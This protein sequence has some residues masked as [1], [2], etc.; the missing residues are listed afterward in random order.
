MRPARGLSTPSG[1][2]GMPKTARAISS[3]AGE[4]GEL[5]EHRVVALAEEGDP[6]RGES[7]GGVRGREADA[8]LS[9][10]DGQDAG[11]AKRVTRRG[12]L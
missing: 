7:P 5:L 9:E 10:I 4:A 8:P 2:R 12:G 11:H 6:R 1:E 3:A